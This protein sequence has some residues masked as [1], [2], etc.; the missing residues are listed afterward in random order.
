MNLFGGFAPGSQTAEQLSRSLGSRTVMSGSISRG[1]NDPSQSLQMMERPL[2]S[3]DELKSMP[4]GS[5]I[6]MKTGVHPMRVQLRLFLDWGIRFRELY[7]VPERAQREVAY[8]SRRDLEQAILQ[9]HP[10]KEEIASMPGKSGY[11]QS[12]RGV[13]GSRGALR[14]EL[15]EERNGIL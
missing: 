12:S 4:K 11:A 13:R 9:R 2:M 5:F 10:P 14:T 3:P 7:Q 15:E 8:A 6:V 1:K